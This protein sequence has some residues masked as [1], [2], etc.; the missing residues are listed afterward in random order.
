MESKTKLNF[1]KE[2]WLLIVS[3]VAFGLLL[4][5]VQAA[6]Q[7]KIEQNA[8]DKLNAS[9]KTLIT[10]AD[11]FE[12]IAEKETVSFAKEPMNLYKATKG[13]ETVGWAFTTVGAGY[14]D[15]I[16]LLIA[17][18][19]KCEKILGYDVLYSNETAG[20]G[21]KI[22]TPFYQDQYKGAPATK[23]TLS[24]LGD[25]K[26]IDGEIVAISG[27]TI[28]SKAVLDIFNCYTAGVNEY[29]AEKGLLQ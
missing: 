22:K 29:L 1:W 7:P 10:D 16:R 25:D 12:V 27:A 20:F 14:A 8:V 21:D 18:D 3:S 11:D 2:S 17:M 6:L 9:L 19:G 4:A 13:G 5:G 15:K 23:L 24:K 26:L 28:S